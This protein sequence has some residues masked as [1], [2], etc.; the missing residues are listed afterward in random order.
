MERAHG[1]CTFCPPPQWLSACPWRKRS[2]AN[3]EKKLA[4]EQ[5]FSSQVSH[6]C[7]A[8]CIFRRCYHMPKKCW[9]KVG[10]SQ[11]KKIHKH[12]MVFIIAR[13]LSEASK[14]H[15]RVPWL[16]LPE[17]TM[18]ARDVHKGWDMPIFQLSGYPGFFPYI[19]WSGRKVIARRFWMSTVASV[20]AVR[21]AQLPVKC[22]GN[23]RPP[24][25]GPG[26]NF[27]CPFHCMKFQPW[28]GTVSSH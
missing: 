8:S 9:V 5:V 16:S 28:L 26:R 24:L 23:Q 19:T 14:A 1:H 17:A 18:A 4:V 11:R 27:P 25:R 7:L 21:N 6:L 3:W 22:M 10:G 20:T 12:W 13:N 2:P 15:V